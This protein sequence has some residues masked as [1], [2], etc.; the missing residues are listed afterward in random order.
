MKITQLLHFDNA[1]TGKK[2]L[3]SMPIFCFTVAMIIHFQGF[4]I[5]QKT[6]FNICSFHYN[7]KIIGTSQ[8]QKKRKAKQCLENCLQQSKIYFSK[9]LVETAH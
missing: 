4:K 7:Y 8:I 9:M 5:T 3:Y 6:F 1:L 2:K